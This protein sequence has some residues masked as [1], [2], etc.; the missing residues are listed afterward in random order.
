MLATTYSANLNDSDN[1]GSG[2]L[3]LAEAGYNS[4]VSE[5]NLRLTDIFTL[6]PTPSARDP[7]RIYLE[8]HRRCST[9]ER[10]QPAG[11]RRFYWRR[12][13]GGASAKS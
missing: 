3:I 4:T 1:V 11:C 7:H 5:Q 8:E 2:G 10:S 13:N 12:R 9:L 6:S